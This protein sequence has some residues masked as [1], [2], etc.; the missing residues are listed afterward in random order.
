MEKLE[1]FLED[2][3]LKK[4]PYQLPRGI[5]EWLVKFA[6]W[7]VILSVVLSVLSILLAFTAGSYLASVGMYA[8]VSFGLRYYLGIGLLAVQTALMASAIPGLK[9]RNKHGW[10]MLFYSAL[11]SVIYSVLSSFTLG[12]M[13][14][15]LIGVAIGLYVLFQMKSYYTNSGLAGALAQKVE[16]KVQKLSKKI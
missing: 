11:I 4:V 9:S 6:P 7:L 1:L 15:S 8:G 13:I 3:F 10:R 5:K 12:N 14:W 2:L 16:E